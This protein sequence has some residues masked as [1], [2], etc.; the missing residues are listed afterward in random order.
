MSDTR[1]LC[2][3]AMAEIVHDLGDGYTRSTGHEVKVEFTR[4]PLVRERIGAGEPFD[5][6]VTT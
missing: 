6:A 1:V 2:S 5:V 3:A 4:S